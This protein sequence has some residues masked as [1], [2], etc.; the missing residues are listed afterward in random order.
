MIDACVAH[1]EERIKDGGARR[2]LIVVPPSLPS[3]VQ[4]FTRLLEGSG[5]DVV[6]DRRL[7]ERR[8]ISGRRTNDRRR[9]DRRGPQRVFGYFQG[10]SIVV[11]VRRRPTS[12]SEANQLAR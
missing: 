9:Q 12:P 8:L 6:V 5:I 11:R 2:L 10:C 4:Y 7:V 3:R 1:E